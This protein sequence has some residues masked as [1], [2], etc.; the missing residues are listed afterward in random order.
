MNPASVTVRDVAPSQL[1]TAYAQHLKKSG[2]IQL[3]PWV[4]VVKTAVGKELS[5]YDSDWYYV[6]A[7]SMLRKI[8][9][10][11]SVG[12]GSFRKIYGAAKTNG[13]RPQH[14]ALG[15]GSIARS[16]LRNLE[17]MR[18]IEKHPK[19]GRRITAEGRRDLDSVARSIKQRLAA[20][21]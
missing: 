6:R 17:T 3:P 8:Y 1:I 7:A 2:G 14:F 18:L 4:D 9:L 5:P 20:N 15:S 16:I 10:N 13:L 19:G 12:I 21:S 11:K